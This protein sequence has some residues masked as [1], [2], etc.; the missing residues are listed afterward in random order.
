MLQR[1]RAQSSAEIWR[2]P[3]GLGSSRIRFNGAALNRARKSGLG[4]RTHSRIPCFNGAALNRARKFSLG[5][6]NCYA[7]VELQR[8][9]A[10]SSAEMSGATLRPKHSPLRASTGPRSIERGNCWPASGLSSSR[11]S[12][13]GAALNRARKLGKIAQGGHTAQL[14]QRG[15]AQSSAEI[16]LLL[17]VQQSCQMLQRGRAQSSAEIAFW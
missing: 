12:F 17:M 13:N 15:R 1:G 11:R 5:C 2:L 16:T 7:S 14:L 4:G 10:Q 9:R 3:A 8:G 6:L